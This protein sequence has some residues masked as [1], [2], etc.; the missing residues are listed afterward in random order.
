MAV[1]K[2]VAQRVFSRHQAVF[3]GE[4]DRQGKHAAGYEF[5]MHRIRVRRKHSIHLCALDDF[6]YPFGHRSLVRID[7][8][9]Q[10]AGI[11][12]GFLKKDPVIFRHGGRSFDMGLHGQPEIIHSFGCGYVRGTV[13]DDLSETGENIV[14][15]RP[16]KPCLA[17]KMIQYQRDAKPAFFGDR[18]QRRAL[19]TL[20]RKPLGCGGDNTLAGNEPLSFPSSFVRLF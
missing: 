4:A 15:A 2:G 12:H 14:D 11:L 10:S 16:P 9:P 1:D 7:D 18:R 19:K 6:E 3:R 20:C 13:I 5:Q 17:R 8:P